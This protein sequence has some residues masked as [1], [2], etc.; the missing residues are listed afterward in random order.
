LVYA[1]TKP[2]KAE[3][4]VIFWDTKTNERY[5][6]YVKRLVAIRACGEY[7]ILATSGEDSGQ[8]I[9]ILCN[10]IGSP[11]DSKYIEVEPLYITM[12]PYHVVA[13]S[14]SSVYT[15]QYRT[16]VS[17]LTSVDTSALNVNREKGRER[18]FHIDSRSTAEEPIMDGGKIRA[19]LGATNDPVCT[20]AASTKVIPSTLH[21]KPEN[22]HPTP[23]TLHPTPYTLSPKP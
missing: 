7:C 6:K 19:P 5:A 8:F 10:A 23:Y 22:L 3:A 9:L 15:W 1:F 20:V 17:K 14:E 11:V 13:A 2:E 4:C 16:L 21:P 18:V 12:T